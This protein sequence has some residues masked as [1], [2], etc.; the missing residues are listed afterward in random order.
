MPVAP[1]VNSFERK[2]GGDQRVVARRQLEQGAIVANSG[3]NLPSSARLAANS[4]N[5]RFFRERQ[6]VSNHNG[7]AGRRTRARE[8]GNRR[9][10][11]DVQYTLWE[12]DPSDAC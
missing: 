11:P 5:Q 8:L 7:R 3:N 4:G 2:I 9:P 12:L 6:D 1:E 10:V